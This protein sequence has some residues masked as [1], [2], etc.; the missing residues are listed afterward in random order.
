M[1]TV[2]L[3]IRGAGIFGLSIAWACARRGARVQVVDPHGVGAGASGGVLGAL[4]PHTPENWNEKKAFQFESLLL[5]ESFWA[6]VDTLSGLSSGYGRTGRLQ[7]LHDDKAI[8]L[9]RARE[10][11]A[12]ALWGE[13]ATW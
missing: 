1:A 11:S 2:D 3:T 8:D 5:A 9:A 7:P 13:A 6:E 10:A 12:A 4:A